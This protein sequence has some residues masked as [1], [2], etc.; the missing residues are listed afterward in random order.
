MMG[1]EHRDTLRL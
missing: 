1:A